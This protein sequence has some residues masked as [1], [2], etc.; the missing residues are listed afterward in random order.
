MSDFEFSLPGG[1]G[2]RRAFRT[3]VPGLTVRVSGQGDTYEVKD[4]SATGLAILMGQDGGF[5]E[6][7]LLSVDLLLGGRLYV[8]GLP[9]RVVVI[10]DDIVAGCNFEEL[11]RRQEARL[12][13]L[14]LEVQ[15]RLIVLTK[16]Q[17]SES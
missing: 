12:D 3:R 4:L 11:D 8:A 6:G 13:R 9:V 17:Q 10:V 7:D 16:S 15:K 5:Q 2:R 14:V 1:E